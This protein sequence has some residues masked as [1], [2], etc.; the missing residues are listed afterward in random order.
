MRRNPEIVRVSDSDAL[1]AEAARRFVELAGKPAGEEFLVALSGGSTPRAL[2]GKLSSMP[3]V[4]EVAWSRMQVFFSDERFVPLTSDESNYH[5]ARQNL[6]SAVPIWGSSVHPVSTIVEP[7]EAA[8]LYEEEIRAV[9]PAG[10]EGVP[11]FDLI[12]LGLGPDGHTASL[13][14]GTEALTVTDR[15]VVPNFVPRLDTWRITFTYTLI[16]AARC[17][18]VLVQGED[19]AE[20]VREVLTGTGDLP[21][22]GVRPTN[23]SLVWLLDAAAARTYE[24]AGGRT[25]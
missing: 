1:A 23:G 11:R 5:L 19:K 24:S 3:Y 22:A 4:D 15:L 8:R 20:R 17:V 13:F 2:Y 7:D 6:L 16:N 21:A 14:P 10:P 25:G 18:M 12:L 9:V